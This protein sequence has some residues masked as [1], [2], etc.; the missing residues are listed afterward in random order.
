M[1]W[2]PL[3]WMFSL[4]FGRW[5][6]LE[7]WSEKSSKTYRTSFRW[8]LL[9]KKKLEASY[10]LMKRYYGC[11][12]DWCSWTRLCFIN[13]VSWIGSKKIDLS[14]SFRTKW[15]NVS[16]LFDRKK[17]GIFYTYVRPFESQNISIVKWNFDEVCPLFSGDYFHMEAMRTKERIGIAIWNT[18]VKEG[19]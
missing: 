3:K 18:R 13:C 17:C 19:K 12:R 16:E 8:R 2:Q 4:A 15:A 7:N 10:M 11:P 6:G 9:L 1:R 14:E 5:S